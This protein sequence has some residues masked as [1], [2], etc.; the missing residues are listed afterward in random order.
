MINSALK[1]LD[2][3]ECSPEETEKGKKAMALKEAYKVAHEAHDL[4]HFKDLLLQHEQEIQQYEQEE[5]EAEE[6]KAAADAEKAEKAEKKADKERRKSKVGDEMEVDEE[7]KASKK[8]KKDVNSDGEGPKVR[9]N[10]NLDRWNHTDSS[11][12]KEDPQGQVEH[13]R[14]KARVCQEE[15]AQEEASR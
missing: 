9:I 4:Q 14:A 10:G 11:A 12:A 5:R 6:R 8:R 13:Q 2:P 7:E 3:E 15:Q 1:K